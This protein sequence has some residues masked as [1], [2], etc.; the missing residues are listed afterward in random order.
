MKKVYINKK[1]LELMPGYELIDKRNYINVRIYLKKVKPF[2]EWVLRKHVM[3][4]L[5]F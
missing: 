2:F 1:I 3:E 5:K 4:I